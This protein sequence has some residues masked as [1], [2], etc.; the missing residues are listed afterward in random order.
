MNKKFAIALMSV[1]LLSANAARADDA[2]LGALL[3]GGAGVLIGHSIAGRNGSV[4]GGAL[5]AA[6]GVAIATDHHQARVAYVPPPVYAP[7]PVYVATPAY[8]APPPVV[9]ETVPVRYEEHRHW[10]HERW[11]HHRD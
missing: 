3:G 7:Q 5:G 8:Y 2:L 1:G 6:A 11:E 10:D 4:I 9:V